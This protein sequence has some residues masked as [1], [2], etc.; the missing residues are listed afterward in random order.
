MLSAGAPALAQGDPPPTVERVYVHNHPRTGDTFG[1]GEVIYAVAIFNEPVTVTGNPRLVLQIGDQTRGADLYN[2]GWGGTGLFFRH[3]VEA[4]DRDDDGIGIPRN[5][6][7]LNRGSIRDSRGNDA[8]LTHEAV[9]D[10]PERKVNGRLDA[11]PSITDVLLT[12]SPDQGDTFGRGES[13]IVLVLFSEPVLVTG[14]PRIAIQVGTQTRQADLHVSAEGGANL[15]FE[16]VVQAADVDADGVSV[17]ADALT[18]NGGSIRDADGNDADLSHDAVSDHPERKVN[19]ASGAPT[20]AAMG[21]RLA[22]AS[23]D[24][25]VAGET[26]FLGVRFTRGVRVTGAPQLTLQV[27]AQ[28]RRAD[29]LPRLR[30]AE[31]LPP[32]SGYHTPGERRDLVYFAYVVQPSDVDDDGV[33]Y[34]ANAFVL[35]GGSIR[36]VDDDSDASLTHDA[37]PDDPRRKVDGS[38]SDDQAPV[39]TAL[40]VVR[41]ARGGVVFGGGDV[42]TVQ[43]AL[44]ER[45]TVTGAPR[46]ALRIGAYT[47]FATF[48]A[49][50]GT[51]QLLFEY[52]VDESDRD[53]NGL[54]IAADAVDLNGGAIRDNAGNDADLDLDYRAFNDDPNYKVNGGLTPVPALPLGG[55]LALLVALLAGGRRRL[56]RRPEQ[57]RREPAP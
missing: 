17:P 32:A 33:S 15:V 25:Y 20:I 21:Y 4:S 30:A 6:L 50:H 12:R 38:R 43:L 11:V 41:P 45:V 18:L 46:F 3:Y 48:R 53:D 39:V 34:P 29:H 35:N 44:S 2:T 1:R 8:D 52:V 47:R 13:L 31:L 40:A 16:Y 9:P 24:T 54:S 14:A 7:L 51:T 28:A 56:M 49:I 10:D 57:R 37:R 19:G 23:Q 55:V 42:I 27:G 36:A 26:I 22:P 5:A